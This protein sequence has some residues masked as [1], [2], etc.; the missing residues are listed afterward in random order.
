MI[1]PPWDGVAFSE[2]DDG[3]LRGDLGARHRLSDRLAVDD[4]WATVRQIH[5][6]DVIA[7]D[8]PGDAGPADAIWTARRG[9]PISV[10]TADCVGVVLSAPGAVGVAHSGWR[11]AAAGV[12][13]ALRESM[14]DAGHEPERA[15][16]GPAIGPCC[17]EVGPEVIERFETSTQ[18]TWGTASID[19]NEAVLRE[20]PGIEVW[21]SGACTFHEPGWF[22]HRKDATGHRLATL[23]WLP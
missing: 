9:L 11:G 13:T 5:G 20:L 2:A 17:F 7:V 18:T 22:S 1:R 16:I 3:D 19:L 4:A 21:M 12:V 14:T 8:S 23:G 10:F 15:A 6:R